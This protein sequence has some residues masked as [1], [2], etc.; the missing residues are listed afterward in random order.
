MNIDVFLLF[1]FCFFPGA[2]TGKYTPENPPSGPRG[3]IYTREFL[4]KVIASTGCIKHRPIC[5][6][7]YTCIVIA[8]KSSREWFFWIS[9][10]FTSYCYKPADF[11]L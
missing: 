6:R 9:M 10:N 8:L 5:L 11:P 1:S 3:R 7:N 2:L 4:T